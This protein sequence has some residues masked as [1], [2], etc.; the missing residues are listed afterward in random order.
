MSRLVFS[1]FIYLFFPLL[2]G[3]SAPG[4][5]SLFEKLNP[6][7]CGVQ[8]TNKL[9]ENEKENLLGF[10]NFYTGSGVGILDVNNDGLPDIFFGGNQVSSR[11]YMNKGDLKFVDITKSAGVKTK[12]WV[13]GVS[14]VDINQ[15]GF[16]D[17]YLSVSGFLSFGNTENLLFINNHDN[18]FTEQAA[19]YNLNEKAQTTHASFFDYDRDGDLDV[20][21]LINPTDFKLNAPG[22][23]DK[24]RTHGEAIST[25]KLYR[26]EGNGKFV[27]VSREAGIFTEGYGLGVNTSDFNRDGLIDIFVSNDY[28]TNDILYINNGDGTF[29]DKLKS[30]F[31][32]T[33]FASMGNDVGDINND[34]RPDLVVLDMLPESSARQKVIVG[35]P[36]YEAYLNVLK[37]GYIQKFSRNVLQLNNGNGTF[38]EI[39]QLAGISKTGWSWGPVLEDLDNDG[40]KDLIVTTGFRRDLG[41]LDFVYNTDHSPFRKSLA[42]ASD[43]VMLMAIMNVKGF[44]IVNYIFKNN[45][46]LTFSNFSV[47]WG[48]DEKSYSCGVAVVDLDNDG[49]NDIVFNNVDQ[50]A[51]LYENK[52]DAILKNHYLKVRL[53]GPGGNKRG[54]GTKL[55]LYQGGKKQYIEYTPYRG[56][57]STMSSDILFGCGK[58]S[59]AD[60]LEI[61]WPD[62]SRMVQYGINTDM[63]LEVSYREGLPSNRYTHKFRKAPVYFEEVGPALRVD[64]R[65]E[66]NPHDDLYKHPLL[67]HQNGRFGPSVAV[68]DIN[69]DGLEDFF[70]GGAHG[71]PGMMFLQNKDFTF[72]S[73]PF[74]FDPNFED[75]GSLLFDYDG[76]ND[77]DLYIVSGGTYTQSAKMYQDRLY[78]ND[79]RG[80]FV[81]THGVLPVITSS[82]GVVSAADFDG[83]DDLDLFVGG[84]VTPGNYPV[85]PRSYLL[86]NREGKFID[87]T[88]EKADGLAFAGMVT[89]ALW[90]DF[91]GDGAVDLIIVGE[92]MPVMIF[93]N[94]K[95]R[96]V[97]ITKTLNL[98][99]TH[100]W[101][102]SINAGDYRGDG[103]RAYVLGNLGFNHSYHASVDYPLRLIAKDFDNN[104]LMDPIMIM[105]Y[106]DGYYPVASRSVILRV[107]PQ[108]KKVFNT[109]NKYAKTTAEAFLDYFGDEGT[110]KLEAEYFATSLLIRGEDGTA[111][112]TPLPAEGQLA[113]V[114]GSAASDLNGDGKVDFLLAGNFYPNNFTQGPYCASTGSVLLSN[115]AQK[116]EVI[117]GHE[118]GFNVRSDSRALATLILGNGE[119]VYIAASNDDRLKVFKQSGRRYQNVRIG[120]LENHAVIEMSSGERRNVE[121]YYGSGYLSQSSRYLDLPDGWAKVRFF[122][123]SGAE[124]QITNDETALGAH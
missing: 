101:W 26:N 15:D 24:P 107:F 85:V 31:C 103:N 69:N 99:D 90:S 74:P 94:E 117:R 40:W 57:M 91:N 72:R 56:Y 105:K 106:V 17:I 121:F 51:S 89:A 64:Y 76:D 36:S 1:L 20:F 77:L 10:I 9:I 65:H 84:R 83:D 47:P 38:S 120:P 110:I 5:P 115:V 39:G 87:V 19:V 102:N 14:I 22:M 61:I 73:V 43:S 98:S 78:E 37:L 123:G 75:L 111:K 4:G 79:G 52:A 18:T 45:G 60:S 23:L 27:D 48:M 97:N 13:T 30:Y 46:N 59:I 42:P 113:P 53:N 49:D 25:D 108:M 67:P 29:T 96:L 63:T 41:N 34:G 119:K 116:P 100:G 55:T 50:R 122:T 66:E 8:F 114:F 58:N 62:G 6:K 16:D 112:L 32:Y 71:F 70:T 95:G 109:Y 124:R 44:P 12:R 81:K 54:H 2:S 118:V 28:V 93:K 80:H 21:L 68:G 3:I 86:E 11:L 7:T 92:W 88:R 104:G 33:S 35:T 82:G